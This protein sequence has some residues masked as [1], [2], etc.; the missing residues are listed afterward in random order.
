M[1][2]QRYLRLNA[3]WTILK[4]LS[5]WVSKSQTD[6]NQIG[7][8]KFDVGIYIKLTSFG[9]LSYLIFTQHPETTKG[10]STYLQKPKSLE[11]LYTDWLLFI[12]FTPS[13]LLLGLNQ[14]NNFLVFAEIYQDALYLN[15]D[16]KKQLKLSN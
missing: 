4:Y 10:H 9:L 12:S 6:K 11:Y 1:M 16:L 14:E 5:I 3:A 8:S 2:T 13:S 7:K 15:L